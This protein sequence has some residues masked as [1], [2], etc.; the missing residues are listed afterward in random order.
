[1]TT[2]PTHSICSNPECRDVTGVP[3]SG[4]CAKCLKNGKYWSLRVP[5]AGELLKHFAVEIAAHSEC[6]CEDNRRDCLYCVA[7]PIADS[8][9]NDSA[10]PVADPNL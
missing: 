1:M 2:Y 10:T 8:E 6:H 5:T 7:T 9:N 4:P 3:P